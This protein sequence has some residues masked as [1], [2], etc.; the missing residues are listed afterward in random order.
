MSELTI[1]HWK[2]HSSQNEIAKL[3]RQVYLLKYTTQI[4]QYKETFS[5]DLNTN[6]ILVKPFVDL[7]RSTTIKSAAH[8]QIKIKKRVIISG[9][10]ETLLPSFFER[11]ESWDI[12]HEKSHICC[13]I[14]YRVAKCLI[15]Y[16]YIKFNKTERSLS[17][18]K[19]E[20][21]TVPA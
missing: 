15:W 1:F 13:Y 6:V 17:D 2:A 11:M 14:R 9:K 7:E 8:V 16:C 3:I 21:F 5:S 19:E 4:Y 12:A 10:I 18:S 20:T